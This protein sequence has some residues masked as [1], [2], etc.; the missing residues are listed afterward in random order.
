MEANID[1]S[2]EVFSIVRLADNL[3][4]QALVVL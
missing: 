2:I 1:L 3:C 4:V